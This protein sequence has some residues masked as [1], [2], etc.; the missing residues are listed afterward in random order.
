MDVLKDKDFK[1]NLW[2][3]ITFPLCR[4]RLIIK[5]KYYS[6]KYRCQRFAR[7]YS[8][9]DVFEFAFSLKEHIEK[10]LR[11]FIKCHHGYVGDE[12]EYEQKLNDMLHH[13]EWM[14]EDKIHDA[15]YK[16][17][18]KYCKEYFEEADS[19]MGEHTEKFFALFK[20]L[21]WSLWD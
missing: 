14:D 11:E 15:I 13:L 16:K 7:G 1:L 5:D 18:N 20:E 19:I 17:Y 21:F 8:D 4:L 3:C 9:E 6:L 10:I 2:D 12:E